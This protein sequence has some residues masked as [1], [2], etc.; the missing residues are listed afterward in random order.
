MF[1]L[2]VAKVNIFPHLSKFLYKNHTI[3]PQFPNITI[4]NREYMDNK[5]FCFTPTPIQLRFKAATSPFQLQSRERTKTLLITGP[6]EW[7]KISLMGII[8]PEE[9]IFSDFICTFA[10]IKMY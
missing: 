4:C 9:V 10:H 1:L 5:Y 6:T 2:F 3:L 8:S 7:G